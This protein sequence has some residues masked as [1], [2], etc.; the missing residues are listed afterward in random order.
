MRW[1]RRCRGGPLEL[2]RDGG[3]GGDCGSIG[4]DGSSVDEF[5][6]AARDAFA[7]QASINADMEEARFQEQRAREMREFIR[8][9][10]APVQRWL[11][12]G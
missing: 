9:H 6:K 1:L 12:L 10:G 11:Q 2:S 3:F 8:S 5:E 4:C 7:H